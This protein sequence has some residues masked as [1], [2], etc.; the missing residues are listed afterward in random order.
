MPWTFA[1]FVPSRGFELETGAVLHRRGELYEHVFSSSAR[2]LPIV[3]CL[4]DSILLLLLGQRSNEGFCFL[5]LVLYQS[6]PLFRDDCASVKT[7]PSGCSC[8]CA[9]IV[10]IHPVPVVEDESGRCE[11]DALPQDAIAEVGD[12]A[13]FFVKCGAEPLRCRRMTVIPAE[14]FPVAQYQ[15]DLFRRTHSTTSS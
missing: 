10:A 1:W 9:K 13:Y 7:R 5:R 4:H 11:L 2:R 6:M 15:L 12:F 8:I 3:P 14:L